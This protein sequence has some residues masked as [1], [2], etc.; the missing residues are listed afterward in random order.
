[1]NHERS[2]NILLGLSKRLQH[3][4]SPRIISDLLNPLFLPPLVLA[5]A[6]RMLGLAT[7][8]ISW[9]LGI[10]FIFYTL[11][12]LGG[13][14]YLLNSQQIASLDIPN[15]I[16]R[17]NLFKLS[18]ISGGLL[19]LVFYMTTVYTHPL[20]TILSLIFFLNTI[21]AFIINHS[22]KI[23]LH[24]A[25][26]ASAGAILLY[27]LGYNSSSTLLSA[28]I[29]SF[30]ILLLLLS[31]M[32]WARYQLAVHTL[33]ELIGGAFAGFVLTVAELNIL[34]SLW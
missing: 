3:A 29:F 4:G 34:V 7:L 26:L 21:A 2:H 10:T 9:I 27:L 30:I 18:T 24:T 13:V 11:I 15:R 1:M 22:W 5:A 20:I 19:F 31:L 28:S 17:G 32:V 14:F 23:S 12:P 6:A 33:P 8:T 16:A 25:T